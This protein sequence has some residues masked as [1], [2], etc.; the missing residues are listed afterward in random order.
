MPTTFREH[1]GLWGRRLLLWK[2]LPNCHWNGNKHKSIS[3]S[4]TC[5]K[6]YSQWLKRS[7]TVCKDLHFAVRTQ[8][9]WN[10]T[11]T[12]KYSQNRSYGIMLG[13]NVRSYLADLCSELNITLSDI[14]NVPKATIRTVQFDIEY[15]DFSQARKCLR[16]W[17]YNMVIYK[18]IHDCK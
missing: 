16:D 9:S 7:A 18:T 10:T 5:L 6:R 2:T 1:F 12:K 3:E 13:Q 11:G 14:F 4:W 15:I 17:L 8:H